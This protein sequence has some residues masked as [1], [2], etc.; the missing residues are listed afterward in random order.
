MSNNVEESTSYKIFYVLFWA[1][2]RGI[3][4]LFKLLW[5][6]TVKASLKNKYIAI[7]YLGLVVFTI[8]SFVIFKDCTIMILVALATAIVIGIMEY[9]K[10]YPVKKKRKYF[11]RLFEEVNLKASDESLPYFLYEN[12]ISE[13]ATSI[14]FG[15]LVPLNTWLSKKELLEMHM[16]VRIS[17]IKQDENNQ[18]IIKLIVETS[19]LPDLIDWDD[20]FIDR[21]KNI[22]NIGI[23]RYG[24][25]GLN[26]EKYPHAFIA[27]ETGSGKSNILKCLIHQSLVKEYDVILIDFKRG[28]S[29][30]AFSDYVDICYEY[31]TVIEVIRNM[32]NETIERLDKFREAKV[33]NINDY[34]KISTD[35]LHRKIIFIDELAELL[36]TRD[37]EIS[38][39][40]NDSIETLTRLSRAVGIHL[41]MGIQRPDSTV[42]SGQ[43]KN[44]VSYRV[45]GRF[46]DKEPSRIMLG[47]D[48]ASTLPNVKGRFIIKDDDFHEVQSFYFYEGNSRLLTAIKEGALDYLDAEDDEPIEADAVEGAVAE[49]PSQKG[50]FEFD[51]SDVGK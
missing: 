47:S 14:S 29:F 21:R 27:G 30:S 18:R 4:E 38:N 43:I 10:E 50:Q 39:I 3:R 46:V 32:V 13:F 23:G 31:K 12:D 11:N 24:M 9:V 48:I 42:I 41:I 34:N 25:V 37:K 7:I 19:P 5:A 33:D 17:D 49:A 2:G 20:D 36:R 28:V 22:L 51:F 8:G 16:N 15:S 45:C 1:L 26:L 6:G 35:Y 40:L 44:N